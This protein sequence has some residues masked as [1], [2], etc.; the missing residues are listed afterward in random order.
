MKK[1]LSLENF[2]KYIPLFI[3]TIAIIIFVKNCHINECEYVDGIQ[4]YSEYLSKRNRGVII[5]NLVL[6]VE[7]DDRVKEEYLK[8]IYKYLED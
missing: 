2:K 1:D 7:F 5:E 8:E 4:V 6:G 3:L